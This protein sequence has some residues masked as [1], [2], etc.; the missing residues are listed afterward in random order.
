VA[1]AFA[2]HSTSPEIW[3]IAGAGAGSGAGAVS[4]SVLVVVLCIDQLS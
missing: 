2:A 3:Y 1:A 4:R